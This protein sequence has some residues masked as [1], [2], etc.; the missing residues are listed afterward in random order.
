MAGCS[1]GK[2]SP[3]DDLADVEPIAEK[4]GEGTA[5]ERDPADHVRPVLR[6]RTLVTI[7][8]SRRSAISG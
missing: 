1:P 4:M 2:T 8:R 7:P 3:E 6:G 5:G